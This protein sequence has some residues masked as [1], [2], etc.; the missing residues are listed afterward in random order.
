MSRELR[1][2]S[3]PGAAALLVFV[4]FHFTIPWEWSLLMDE[5]GFNTWMPKVPDFFAALAGEVRTYWEQGRFNPAKYA[6]NLFKW[7]YLPNDPGVQHL[8]SL[9]NL[10]FVLAAGSWAAL[11]AARDT[12]AMPAIDKAAWVLILC[13]FGLLQR[14][15]LDIAALNTIPESYVVVFFVLGLLCFPKRPVLYRGFFVLCALAKEPGAVAFLGSAV[16]WALSAWL[17]SQRRRAHLRALA[18]D[19]AVFAVLAFVAFKAKNAGPYLA[20]YSLTDPANAGKFA[21]GLVKVALGLIP[22]AILFDGPEL[23]KSLTPLSGAN[24]LRLLC[25]VFGLCYLFLVTARVP[26][27][28]L[29]LPASFAFFI[30]V[31][32]LMAEAAP[33]SRP[34]LF[35]FALMFLVFF[36]VSF[37]RYERF[38]RGINASTAAFHAL[39]KTSHPRLILMEANEA[40][41]AGRLIAAKRGAPVKVAEVLKDKMPEARAGDYADVVFLEFTNYFGRT[42]DA[43]LEALG[44]RFGGW[45]TAVDRGVYRVFCTCAS[46]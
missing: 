46:F 28:Y 14:P 11:R 31:A 15:L 33:F 17:D 10:L 29:V 20:G 41:A 30:L 37:A 23:K 18:I 7:R 40:A 2:L 45:K 34:K 16:V 5:A 1:I 24:R 3:F 43:R 12:R 36:S 22:A 4:V 27:G 19:A 6:I 38:T 21:L 13:G 35:A 26:A 32:S 9:L 8:V 44:K 39:L 42:P 25:L